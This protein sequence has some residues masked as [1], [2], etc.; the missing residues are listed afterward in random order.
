MENNK[1]H[2]LI[3]PPEIE[4]GGWNA[5]I[6]YLFQ[7]QL[8]T[9]P[10]ARNHYAQFG[11]IERRK[12]LFDGFYLELQH[13]P[14]RE[15]STCADVSKP[16]IENRPCFL[17][18]NNLPSEQKG[19]SILGKYLILVN[20]FPIFKRHLTIIDTEHTA[21]QIAGRLTDLLTISRHLEGY[22]VFYNG[23]KCGASA[24][25][26][27]HFQATLSNEMP[28]NLQFDALKISNGTLLVQ[29]D[30]IQITLIDGFLRSAIVLESEYREPIDYFFDKLTKQLPMDDESGEPMLNLLASYSDG[31]YR[32]VVFPR[33]A[34][35]PSCYFKE[36]AEKIVVS[37]ASVELSG[38]VVTP[39]EEDFKKITKED[40]TKI[41]SEVS[42]KH[43]FS[44]LTP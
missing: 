41:F 18:L 40:L 25:D 37:V 24:P 12:V 43:T 3:L 14:A 15:R 19:L 4:A 38:V 22:T 2:H 30:D 27:F 42:R 29:A 44:K 26:H 8:Y 23:P 13:N 31:V 11:E 36:G 6:E 34:Q 21:Q 39:R 28:I 17:C 10:M 5:T 9:W 1:A 33:I 7:Q 32:L 16:A 20:P 35:R